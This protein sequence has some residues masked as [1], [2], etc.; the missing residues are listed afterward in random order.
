SSNWAD[1][2]ADCTD[3]VG[4]TLMNFIA[5]V[6]QSEKE[7][8]MTLNARGEFAEL[9]YTASGSG[10]PLVLFPLALAPSQW[11]PLIPA[12]SKRHCTIVLSGAMVGAAA[13]LEARAPGYLRV[14]RS[15]MDELRLHAGEKVLEVG[16]GSGVILRWLAGYTGG[17]N[18]LVGIDLNLYLLREA[19]DLAQKTGIDE[20][21]DLAEGNAESLPFP[22]NC[23]DVT[24][25]CTVLEEGNAD[26]MLAECV[27]VTKPGGRVG[28]LVRS[29]DM[30]GWVNLPLGAA[31]KQKAEA[32]SGSAEEH[33]CADASLYQRLLKV[34]LRPLVIF[35]Q[36]ATYSDGE[37]LDYMEERILASL[38][39]EQAEEWRQARSRP[40]S[41]GTFF[42]AQPFHCAL[43]TKR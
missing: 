1:I 39:P 23:F 37:R 25:A 9:S 36:W 12:L 26:R 24:I 30:P 38:T 40:E 3:L 11:Q 21:L 32:Q 16:C 28:A 20:I 17:A 6:E 42:I 2:I 31:L 13:F 33:G 29:I 22:D 34:G 27:R 19:R 41:H 14:V 43:G 18:R 35:P 5:Q 10:T 8:A 15:L 7:D 4:A